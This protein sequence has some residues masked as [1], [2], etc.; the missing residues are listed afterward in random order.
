MPT[1]LCERKRPHWNR[2]GGVSL[3]SSLNIPRRMFE[4]AVATVMLTACDVH[5]PVA[6]G[7]LASLTVT[8][9]VT[10][11]I[12]GTQQ[13]VAVGRDAADNIVPIAPTWS[14]AANGGTITATGLLTAGRTLGPFRVTAAV[15]A[16][17]AFATATVVAGPAASITVTPDVTLAINGTQQFVAVARDAGNNVVP[18][19]PTWAVATNGGTIT[20]TGFLTAGTTLGSFAVTATAGA[21]SGFATATVVA[22]PAASIIVTP[23]PRTLSPSGTQ[24]F[25]AVA[26]DAGNNVVP[27]TPSWTVV[28]GGGTISGSGIFTAGATVGTFTNTVRAT[29]GTL[30][31]NATV[32]VSST[33]AAFLP[34]GAAASHGILAGTAVSCV[35]GGFIGADIG[36]APGSTLTGFGPC[37][38]SG[39]ANLGNAIAQNAQNDLTTAYNTL[40]GLPCPPANAIVANLGG[41]TKPA[42]VYCSASGIGVTG[43]LTLDGGG[44]PNAVFVFQAGSSLTTA[45]NIVLINQAQAKNVY[46]QVGSSATI[47]SASQWQ[48]NILALSSI[49]LIDTA[50]LLGRALARNGAVSLTS[51]NT[52]TLP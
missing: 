15:G 44:D 51:N 30:S 16:L 28:N 50:T 42:G 12:N 47:G 14:V 46:W 37:T 13:F 48:G 31:G 18:I 45:G 49:S 25:T 20:G 41:T 2:I 23:N 29:S 26:R 9:D 33:T 27:I 7:T 6:P 39:V 8:P 1:L 10:L 24:Q 40:A 21:L 5:T 32:V 19:T 4:V 22:G 11:G 38:Y 3:R 52:I 35:I 17:S 34:L 43:T 36:V